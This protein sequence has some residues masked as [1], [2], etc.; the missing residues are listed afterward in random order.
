MSEKYDRYIDQHRE[1]VYEAFKWL[2]KYIPE[3][4]DDEDFKAKCEYQCQ[5]DH[6]YSKYES[7]E[8]PAYDAYFYGGNRSHEVV[9]NFNRAWLRHIHQNPHHWQYWILIN[10]NPDEGEIILDMPNNYI[11]EMVCDWWSFSWRQEKLD[12]IFNWYDEH[13]KYMKLSD[14]TRK[15]VEYILK[16]IREELNESDVNEN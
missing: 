5:Y 1:N 9:E 14:K 3:I 13:S 10:D 7:E 8:Y 12:E 15:K 2:A 16:R 4:F 6:D 11:I